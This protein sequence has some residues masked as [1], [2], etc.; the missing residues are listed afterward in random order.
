[1]P[2]S[3]KDLICTRDMATMLGSP[4][5]AG[6]VPDDDDV[7]VER[8][9]AAG[10]IPIGKTNTPEFGY[11]GVGANALFP[12]TVNPWH[13][14]MTP[15]GSSAGSAAAVASGM[16]AISIGS[17]GGGSIRGPVSFCGLV[18]MKPS[19]GR[20]PLWPG[21]RDPR[22]PGMSS[23][24]TIEHIGPIARTV[25]DAALL[26]SVIAG[27][28]DRDRH[29]LRAGD[30]DWL[31]SVAAPLGGVR[32]AWTPDF[33]FSRVDA[34]VRALAEAAARTFADDL[35]CE[36]VEDTP[37]L[38]EMGDLFLAIVV[39]DS[40]LAGMR[41]LAQ[42]GGITLP[43]LLGLLRRGWTAE[44]FTNA[45]MRRQAVSNE[46]ARFMRGYD[47]LLTPTVSTPAFP[48]GRFRPETI[49]AVPAQQANG[50]PFTYP[51]NWSGQPAISVPAGWTAAGLPV[52]LQIIG[53]HLADGTVLRAAA[54]FEAA[55]PWADRWPALVAQERASG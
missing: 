3:I 46:L 36:L 49:E 35:G 1:M 18:G 14:G 17:D 16:G 21:C 26:L 27:P 12:P 2:L 10:A 6:F 20:V 51:F 15:G 4:A 11:A 48:L 30:V 24:E 7:C 23:W 33:G 31:G 41:S 8:V 5:Y 13:L 22:F 38:E 39:R 34:E 9:R 43:G 32:V 53:R 47:L 42:N 37:R 19:F 45:A 25:K 54:A 40:D 50:S 29:S 55:R 52:G 28:D 44:D